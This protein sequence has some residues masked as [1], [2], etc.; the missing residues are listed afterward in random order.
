MAFRTEDRGTFS[1][2]SNDGRVWVV[3]FHGHC[4]GRF[5]PHGVDV[6]HDWFRQV[7]GERYIRRSATKPSLSDWNQFVVDMLEHHGVMVSG[8]HRPRWVKEDENA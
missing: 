6:H 5:S 1:I 2:I 4:V 8:V 7:H 3:D